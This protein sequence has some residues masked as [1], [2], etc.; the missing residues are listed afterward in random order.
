MVDDSVKFRKGTFFIAEFPTLPSLTAQPRRV[1]LYEAQRTHSILKME[2]SAESPLWFDSVKTGAPVKFSWTQDTLSRA[3]IGYVSDVSKID[4]PERQ[5]S[6]V[7]TCVGATYPLKERVTRVF[8][9][10]TI[11]QAIQEVVEEFGFKFITENHSQVFD[12]LVIPGTSYWEWIQEQGRRIG[13]GVVVDRMN[14]IFKPLDRLIDMNFSNAAVLSM[15]DKTVPF[16][17]QY[18]DRTLDYFKVVTGDNVQDTENVRA[19]KNVGGVDPITGVP[20][21]A[22]KSPDEI[23]TKL[24]SEV[25]DVLFNEYRTERV[26]NAQIDA[27][28]AAT[29]TAQLA[30]FNIPARVK[31]QGDPRISP[32]GSV[33]IN[34]TGSLTDGFWIVREA[35][36]MFHKVGD[37]IME[38][39]VATD[40]LGE[41]AQSLFRTRGTNLSGTVNLVD[42]V[43]SNATE[44]IQ[45]DSGKAALVITSPFAKENEQGF[46]RNPALWKAV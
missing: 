39:S 21:M 40:G 10:T 14:F 28:T 16:N 45:L 1:D 38:L 43:A 27:A 12:Q 9:N 44:V 5:T 18:L 15:G 22:S 42:A 31:C 13:Y 37:Y 46:K 36:H 8:K 32:F 11:P 33:Y 3:F 34:G 19:V 24:R 29:D 30:R 35:H 41:T 26:V 20:F 2:F 23:G 17:T 4:A 25:S 7:L 6:M